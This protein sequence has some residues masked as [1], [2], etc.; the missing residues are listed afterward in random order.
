MQH[1]AS[2]HMSFVSHNSMLTPGER[3]P[4]DDTNEPMLNDDY[5]QDDES[6][7]TPNMVFKDEPISLFNAH[8]LM[9]EVNMNDIC[10]P[11]ENLDDDQFNNDNEDTLS[12][13]S[14]NKDKELY[15][16]ES[17]SDD[18]LEKQPS[19]EV[20]SSNY[21][22]LK[23]YGSKEMKREVWDSLV[24][25]WYRSSMSNCILHI[26]GSLSFGEQKKK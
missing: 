13:E 19:K 21:V 14:T 3:W 8:A 25:V 11:M 2:R 9:E 18:W 15:D 20:N 24:H 23:G 16:S 26:G 10:I 6:I 22:D 7:R 5:Y 12:N 17:T 4:D 1:L